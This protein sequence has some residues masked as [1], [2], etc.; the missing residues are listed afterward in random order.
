MRVGEHNFGPYA[1]LHESS[2]T[3]VTGK[4]NVKYTLNE[5][6]SGKACSCHCELGWKPNSTKTAFEQ[7]YVCLAHRI[8]NG[9]YDA[10]LPDIIPATEEDC[11]AYKVKGNRQLMHRWSYS[12]AKSEKDKRD[13]YWQYRGYS[14]PGSNDLRIHDNVE[15]HSRRPD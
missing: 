3:W 14:I 11:K 5:D 9:I 6:G 15:N 7:I 10:S 13:E 1:G 12:D 4:G 8:V 2:T